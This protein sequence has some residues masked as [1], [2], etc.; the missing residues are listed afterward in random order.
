MKQL[1]NFEFELFKKINNQDAFP[2]A[3]RW[4]A[5]IRKLPRITAAEISGELRRGKSAVNQIEIATASTQPAGALADIT[6]LGGS[7]QVFSERD[8]QV[9]FHFDN[10]VNLIV[11]VSEPARFGNLLQHTTGSQAH[12]E[13]LARIAGRR[14]LNYQSG[15]IQ[16][17]DQPLNFANETELYK[18]LKLPCIPPELREGVLESEWLSAKSGQHLIT[19][20]DI[21]ADLHVH[22]IWSDGKNSLEEM[23]EAAVEN[24]LSLIAITDHSPYLLRKRYADH[25]YLL[26]QQEEIS[27]L[28]QRY[29][30]RLEILKGVEVD[31]FPDGSLDLAEEVLDHIDIIIASVHTDLDQPQEIITA[32]YIRA[33]EHPFVHIIGH[34]GGR[35]FPMTDISDLDWD[36]IFQA[37]ARHQVAL[38]INSHKSHPLFD[39]QKVRRAAS[40]GIPIALNSDSHHA[41]MFADSRYGLLIARRAGLKKDQIINTWPLERIKSWLRE[42]VPSARGSKI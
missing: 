35:L 19:Q 14:G 9:V 42:K 21:L 23:A 26:R 3:E 6:Y 11:W 12:N 30:G 8:D 20:K 4:L 37:A 39:D 16:Q 15:V 25:S 24:G 7:R 29:S 18:F 1:I 22:S 10:G 33:I 2:L 13:W 32:R 36:S 40:S 28:R 5:A 27:C 17:G 38:E 41:G 31:I 34:P